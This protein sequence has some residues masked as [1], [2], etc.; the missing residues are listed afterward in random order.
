MDIVEGTDLKMYYHLRGAYFRKE[1][2]RALDGVSLNVREGEIFGLVGETGSGK[3]TIARI[4]LGL[5]K[6]TSGSV[7]IEGTNIFSMGRKGL[8]Q[9]RTKI[10]IIFQD[11][12]SALDPRFKIKQILEE[13]LKLNHIEYNDEDIKEVME[14]AGL[15]PVEDFLGK[16]PYQL[17][18]G[19]RQRVLIARAMVLRPKFLI[20]DEPA[21]MLD[22][23]LKAGILN[24]LKK[25]NNEQNTSMLVI[26]HDIA[27]ASY[28]SQEIA[29][30]YLGKIAERASRE[31]IVKNPLHP[32]TKILI[33]SVPELGR[34]IGDVPVSS[35]GLIH[36]EGQ[37]GCS[38]YPRCQF[39]TDLCKFKEPILK[40][41]SNGHYV[42][43]HLY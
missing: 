30:L 37:Y 19:Q 40:E 17:S 12:Y 1:F 38:F 35:N 23:S 42:A 6:P 34:E 7:K 21:S 25:I 20:A 18:G 8:R 16:H 10:Q 5:I 22:V 32:Y 43:C 24:Y 2:V 4:M 9:V 31:E 14:N 39:A 13:P 15:K 27:L 11:P 29:V 3:T 33:E 28:L 26:S 41:I 36:Q